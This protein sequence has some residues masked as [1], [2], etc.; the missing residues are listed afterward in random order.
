MWKFCGLNSTLI[1][2]YLGPVTT[3]VISAIK[4]VT[5]KWSRSTKMK[6]FALLLYST[7]LNYSL[8]KTSPTLTHQFT[9]IP[10]TFRFTPQSVFEN[11]SIEIKKIGGWNYS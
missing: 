3:M 9:N 11:I 6:D 2:Y 10:P 4:K 1:Y 8:L 7:G 5:G